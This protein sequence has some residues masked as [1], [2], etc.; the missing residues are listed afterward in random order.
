MRSGKAPL[1]SFSDLAQFFQAKEEP[2]PKEEPEKKGDQEQDPS[3][4]T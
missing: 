4:Q 3:G 1:R 2:P